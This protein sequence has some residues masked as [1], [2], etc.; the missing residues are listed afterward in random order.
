MKAPLFLIAVLVSIV[1]GAINADVEKWDRIKIFWD[2]TFFFV[3]RPVDWNGARV[4][5]NGAKAAC[6]DMGATLAT[7]TSYAENRF[8]EKAMSED[9]RLQNKYFWIGA[10]CPRC[11]KIKD[12]KWEW[13]T[14]EPLPLS[15][16]EWLQGRAMCKG[17]CPSDGGAPP[18]ATYLSVIKHSSESKGGFGY[19]NWS[20]AGGDSGEGFI[21]KA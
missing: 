4:D 17:H 1:G 14:G 15:F 5:W 7:L 20:V 21:C 19:V 6:K 13:I 3:E 2:K 16:R 9:P 10:H 8:L 11:N 12:D 18:T